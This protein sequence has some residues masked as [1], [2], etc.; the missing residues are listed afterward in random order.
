MNQEQTIQDLLKQAQAAQQSL[1]QYY[2]SQG[3]TLEFDVKTGKQLKPAQPLTTPNLLPIT[4][5]DLTPTKPVS[6]PN[7]QSNTASVALAS[8]LPSIQEPVQQQTAP[9]T[10]EQIQQQILELINKQGTQGEVAADI[11]KQEGVSEKQKLAQDLTKQYEQKQQAYTKKI[12]QIRENKAGLFGG[13][14]EQEV[15]NVERQMNS[16][17]ADIAIQQKAAVGDY[18]GAMEIADKKIAAQFEPIDNQIKGLQLVYSFL[19]DDL[20]ESEKLQA[21]AAIQ[22]KQALMEF[23]MQKEMALYNSYLKFSSGIDNGTVGDPNQYTNDLDA[24]IGATLATIPS[25]FGQETF[26]N[27]IFKARNEADKI[28]LVAS[29]VLQGAPATIKTDFTNQ[30]T[31]IKEIDKAI[32][33]LDQGTQ[34]GVLNNAA[35]Y[36]YNIFGKDFDP[37]LAQINGYIT[38]AIQPYRSTIT[39]AAW[40]DQEDAEYQSLFGSTKYS[41]AELRQRLVQVKELLATKSSQALNSFVNP[42]GFYSNPFET[43]QFGSTPQQSEEQAFDSVISQPSAKWSNFWSS[44]KGLFQ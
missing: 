22:E 11:Y 36:T 34:T 32:A 39:G 29:M 6:V 30:V 13:A 28:N 2:K 23:A 4:P 24:L 12:E 37:K 10:R 25:K 18:T 42:L 1:N 15:A 20:T 17:L 43:G 27:Q 33:L 9:S 35:Q 38:A 40:G 21:Q 26:K 41:P 3:S 19:Q 8:S 44:L 5:S 14:V 7:V 16:E 31:G